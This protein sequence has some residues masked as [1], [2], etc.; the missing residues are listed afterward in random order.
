MFQTIGM[1]GRNRRH[2]WLR[3]LCVVA[4]LLSASAVVSPARV[5]LKVG[6]SKGVAAFPHSNG[7][8]IA[9]NS[10][11]TWFV[12]Y[13][14]RVGGKNVIFLAASKVAL[15]EFT[16]D[17]HSPV[18]VAGGSAVAVVR[19][20]AAA[21]QV[22]SM[23]VDSN[24]VLHLV[25]QSARP[26]G[27]W[28][29]RCN[30]GGADAA[31]RIAE[32][33]NWTRVD[34]RTPGAERIDSAPGDVRLGDIA[35]GPGGRLWIAY[36]QAVEV[37]EGATYRF[38]DE[39]KTSIYRVRGQQ[40]YQVWAASPSA[41]HWKRKRLTV[42]GAF[43]S[44]VMDIDPEGVLHLTFNSGTG[45]RH[46]SYLQLADFATGFDGGR[47][48]SE[49]LPHL[50]WD[51]TGVVSHSVVGWGRRALVVFERLGHVLLYAFFDGESWESAALHPGPQEGLQRPML[52]RDRHG[53]AWV[54]WS[55]P[56]RGHTFYS[57]WLGTR[58]S[59]PYVGRTVMEGLLPGD[60]AIDGKGPNLG[61]FHTAQKQMS[62]EAEHLGV[63]LAS[64]ASSGGVFFDL[65]K[66]PALRLENQRKVLFLDMLE[67]SA[68]EGLVETFHPMKKHSANPVL[69]P[70]PPGSWD[71]RRAH[72]YGEVLYD[73][74]KF[75]MWYSG[76]SAAGAQQ[77]MTGTTTSH[78]VGY[79]ESDDGVHWVKPELG[80]LEYNGS[81]ANNI[82]D[83]GDD[84]GH[85]YMPMVVKDKTD[86]DPGRRYKIIAERLGKDTLHYSADGYQW[87]G[88]VRV[89][90]RGWSDRRSLFYDTLETNPARRWKVY[91]HCG[92]RAP[93]GLRK[94]CRD[95]SAD[96]VHWTSDPRN[97]VM[98]PRAGKPLEHHLTSVWIDGQ[99]Y[100]GMI[101]AWQP[102]Q[103]QPQQLIASRD[104]VNFVYVFDG[105]HVIELGEPGAWDG[106]WTS[107]VN[108]PVVVG[109]ELW[110]YYSGSPQTIG[111]YRR[112][113]VSEPMST[114]LATI[115]RDGFVSLDVEDGREEGSFE[116]IPVELTGRPM[117]LGVNAA[118]L[119]G[120][121]GSI[122][123]EVL[124]GDRVVATSHALTA[125]GVRVPVSWQPGGRS[126]T[127][128]QKSVRL[129]FRLEGRARIYSFTLH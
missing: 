18:L 4:L 29:S 117:R 93:K 26:P 49:E 36:S 91:S 30:V 79:A 20:G 9:R 84:G 50:L 28:Y 32:A 100:V 60:E 92:G 76:W 86:P 128:P 56:A 15:P 19:N 64:T 107:S 3:R 33:R 5:V 42:P 112:R 114:G 122:R 21:A 34:D 25:W 108:V 111:G 38:Q 58:F 72:A 69:K 11:G 51:G 22:A 27:I 57:R 48:F 102:T 17:F 70:G 78:H 123:V 129:R 96:L 31:R 89:D 73:E 119:S 52:A 125:D 90:Q 110:M 126:L 6:E 97:P 61:A 12:A 44:P 59:A 66:V 101:D 82:V 80:Q 13:D 16:G 68:V 106:G 83:L 23:V 103:V 46:L 116:T 85:A 37:R 54:F 120:G 10:Q 67:V 113:W 62:A 77:V 98:H 55:N 35:L 8:Q 45:R 87:S 24:D 115:R 121:K 40:A 53:M 105:K 81:T 39:G 99:M 124:D 43:E 2:Y 95:W 74:G 104:G 127:L 63:A 1:P 94:T 14:G 118:G 88:G 71:D 47:E 109:D 7:R 75:R 41:G 65:V